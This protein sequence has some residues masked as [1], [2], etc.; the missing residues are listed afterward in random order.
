MSGPTANEIMSR[1]EADI[2]SAV[3]EP[4]ERLPSVRRHA[5][6]LSVSP[7][8]VAAA[9]RRLRER[10]LVMGRGR[11]GTRV[12]PRQNV[13]AGRAP[14]IPEAVI[15]A[16]SGNPDP[17][18]LPSLEAAL[19]QLSPA[20]PTRYGDP[21]IEPE[22]GAVAASL[23]RNDGVDA[24]HITV[25]SGAMHAIELII[26]T[27]QF[28]VGDRLAVED[29]GHI[30]VHQLGRQAGMELI[31][32]AVDD[33]GMVPDSLR[34]ALNSGVAAVVLTPRVQNPTGAALSPARAEALGGILT[35]H[36]GVVLI[37]DD[38]AGRVS[39]VEAVMV[40]PQ[41]PRWATIRS[42]GKSHGPDLRLA[43]VAGDLTTID[44]IEIAVSTGPGWVSR[45]LQR[46][47]V[48]LLT[49]EVIDE[50]ITTAEAQYRDRRGQMIDALAQRGV[51]ATGRSGLNVWVPV[52]DEQA[53]IEAARVAGY[54]I[55][56][57]DSYRVKSSPAVRI[58]I[59]TLS[60]SD[61]GTLARALGNHL[62]GS[63]T[64][65]AV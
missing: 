28:R 41:G 35:D 24:D 36:P 58:T 60:E 55:R 39:G 38:H 57:G 48:C 65:S 40:E 3:L 27:E 9:Y 10:G 43:L 15:D 14:A 63:G 47:A 44:R 32:V 53:A 51:T 31:P 23:F 12:A 33:E 50:L 29:P 2:G 17:L 45:L 1:I 34:V 26:T 49:D 54:A 30:P 8:T 5:E 16:M 19:Q 4:G 59:T 56:G 20:P 11:Q 18:V 21:L 37:Q 46:T 7:A 52:P 42:L 64:S 13:T 6:E 22:L 62:T 25:T 61:I